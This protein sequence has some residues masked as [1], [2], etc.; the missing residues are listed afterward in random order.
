MKGHDQA[1]GHC[2]R[3]STQHTVP[4]YV[5]GW[6]NQAKRDGEFHPLRCWDPRGDGS[7]PPAAGAAPSK[8]GNSSIPLAWDPKTLAQ[9][10]RW[11]QCG[12]S[13]GEGC[14]RHLTKRLH[15]GLKERDDNQVATEKPVDLLWQSWQ[16]LLLYH[17]DWDSCEMCRCPSS[18]F[19]GGSDAFSQ[20]LVQPGWV[21]HTVTSANGHLS[22]RPSPTLVHPNPQ[23]KRAGPTSLI[24]AGNRSQVTPGKHGC[25]KL[26]FKY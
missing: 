8:A 6:Q 19:L 21:A 2:N 1:K 3:D 16:A 14:Y 23:D 22:K 25:R 15:T 18:P 26:S 10:Y 5:R 7:V 9:S 12:L 13:Q 11:Q 20:W 4:H 17:L 24:L